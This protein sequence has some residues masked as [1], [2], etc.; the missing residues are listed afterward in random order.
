MN[1]NDKKVLITG[2]DGFIG[3]H[4][5][6]LILSKGAEVRALTL[7][8]SFNSWGWLEDI[9]LNGNIENCNWGY[10]RLKFL[11]INN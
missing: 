11:F 4:L 1:W 10:K 2:S 9:D 8:N 6:E 5:C 7:Y 3:S